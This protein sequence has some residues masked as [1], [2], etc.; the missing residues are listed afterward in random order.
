MPKLQ[1]NHVTD[2]ALYEDGYDTYGGI[3]PFFDAVEE[4]TYMGMPLEEE[5]LSSKEEI[6]ALVAK[7]A[8]PVLNNTASVSDTEIN[9]FNAK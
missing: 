4:E 2:D 1:Q 6:E 7:A 3:G 9:K 8:N 5:A